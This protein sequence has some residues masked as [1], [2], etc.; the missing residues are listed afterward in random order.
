MSKTVVWVCVLISMLCVS[1]VEERE[2]PLYLAHCLDDR[3]CPGQVQCWDGVCVPG[4]LRPVS[5]PKVELWGLR[6]RIE[7]RKPLIELDIPVARPL[8][9]PEY[10]AFMDVMARDN[11]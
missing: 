4:R 5:P 2:R 8:V 7:V 6:Q 9:R 3:Q 11:K 1:C 10:E